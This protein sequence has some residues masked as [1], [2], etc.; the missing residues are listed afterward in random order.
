M[1]TPQFVEKQLL[2]KPENK[3]VGM[4]RLPCRLLRA[5]APVIAHPLAYI[6]NLSLQSGKF[7]S[8]WKYHKVLP[9]SRL[10]QLWREIAIELYQVCQYYLKF[11]NNL[12]ILLS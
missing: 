11:L 12:Y 7:I 8:E 1:Y 6:F 10:A 3:A 5:V 4:D 9:F 2:S